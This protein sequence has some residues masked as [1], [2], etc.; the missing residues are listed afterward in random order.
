M[1]SKSLI[2]TIL[3]VTAFSVIAK[4]IGFI[5]DIILAQNFGANASMDAYYLAQSMPGIIFPAVGAS[6]SAAFITLYAKKESIDEKN[7]F[8]KESFLN[9]LIISVLLTIIAV[10]IIPFVINLIAPGFDQETLNIA[11]LL[12]TIT[13]SSF[14]FIMLHYYLSAL[15]NSN[16]KFYLI[17]FSGILFNLMIIIPL[18]IKNIVSDVVQLTI[19]IAIAHIIQTIVVLLFSSKYL[20]CT[21]KVSIFN[22]QYR[23]LLM[24]AIP[25]LVGNSVIQIQNIVDKSLATGMNPGSLSS[26]SYGNTLFNLVISVMI[27]SLSTVLY[28]ILADTNT[29]KDKTYLVK[30]IKNACDFIIL[31]ILPITILIFFNSNLIVEIVYLRGAFNLENSIVTADVLKLL[32]ISLI[33]VSLREVLT[34][35]F[36]ASNDSRT[37]MINGIVSVI[38][39]VILSILLSKIYGL[40]GIVMATTIAS[41]ISC[42]LMVIST[43]KIHGFFPSSFGFLGFSKLAIIIIVLAII[44][45]YG[46]VQISGKM[47]NLIINTLVIFTAYLLLLFAFRI[48]LKN[49]IKLFKREAK[50]EKSNT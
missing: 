48:N 28:P 6:L 16:K 27:I 46:S 36:Y 32:S 15:L 33:F 23:K 20:K 44:G 5:R 35:V 42:V 14:I 13:M 47:L 12:S 22:S 21:K 29:Q 4:L 17:Q 2:K 50:N 37:P 25:I 26:L 39:N 8:A 10:L 43:I 1:S 34:R 7:K 41:F 3:Y 24:L 49:T 9:T 38:I 19:T 40:N 11:I 30:L 31:L 18:Y 45:N